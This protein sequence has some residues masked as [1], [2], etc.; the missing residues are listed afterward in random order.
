MPANQP[1][2]ILVVDDEL[3]IVNAV[4]REL[5]TQPSGR[6]AYEVEAFTDPKA[7]LARAAAQPFDL[8]I[9]DYRMPEIDGLELLREFSTLQ[10][11]CA[12]IVLSG[13]TDLEA[14]VEMVN[15]E[16]VFRFIAKPW[17]NHTLTGSVRQALAYR[18]AVLENR[19]LAEEARVARIALP[20]RDFEDVDHIL[21]VDDDKAVLHA[22]A[23]EI[24]SR[25]SSLDDIH[26]ALQ[27]ERTGKQV[28]A[29]P[30]SQLRVET[31]DNPLQALELAQSAEYACIVAD[32][33]MPQMN[34]LELLQKFGALQPDCVRIL[35]SAHADKDVLVGALNDAH[36]YSYL[37]KPWSKYELKSV[38]AQ[39]LSQRNMLIENRLLA[40]LLQVN[41]EAG[42]R[43]A[44]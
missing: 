20:P 41:R 3:S 32:Y 34:G 2:R 30:G 22:L 1:F 14:L 21:L 23:R 42:E 24:A 5:T 13:Q 37:S 25:H 12:R 10:P 11:D 35:L 33:R 7:A 17:H 36:I 29:L 6:G 40:G 44:Y 26:A 18:A 8:L 39:A 31:C 15:R 38:I 19:R 28:E 27:Y 4:R 16:H 9:T 43:R